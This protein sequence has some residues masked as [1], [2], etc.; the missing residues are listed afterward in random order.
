MNSQRHRLQRLPLVGAAL[1]PRKLRASLPQI[2]VGLSRAG[3]V[4]ARLCPLLAQSRHWVRDKG[5]PLLTHSGHSVNVTGPSGSLG[6]CQLIPSMSGN[7]GHHSATPAARSAAME[8]NR[9]PVEERGWG[10]LAPP[11]PTRCVEGG[12]SSRVPGR[13]QTAR[14]LP[15]VWQTYTALLIF[16]PVHCHN[17][18]AIAH[19]GRTL[20]ERLGAICRSRPGGADDP[21]G[22]NALRGEPQ[23]QR[24]KT[25]PRPGEG[26]RPRFPASDGNQAKPPSK[27]K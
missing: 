27:P 20:F 6:V 16:V 23:A 25:N 21:E 7:F 19:K 5:C 11:A 13:R 26:H 12:S 2:V 4:P 1:G 15:S 17:E 14:P 18:Y 10:M 22:R 9:Q 24:G 3:N 8:C